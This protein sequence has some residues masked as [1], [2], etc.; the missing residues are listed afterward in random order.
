MKIDFLEAVIL[1]EMLDSGELKEILEAVDLLLE[2]NQP[3]AANKA[4]EPLNDK[5]KEA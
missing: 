4:L 3:T 2:K 1:K 5:L